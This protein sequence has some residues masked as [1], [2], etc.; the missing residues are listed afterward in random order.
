MTVHSLIQVI[1]QNHDTVTYH[2]HVNGIKLPALWWMFTHIKGESVF[3]AHVGTFGW[4]I[5]ST[6]RLRFINL[7]LQWYSF[8]ITKWIYTKIWHEFYGTPV[9][10]DTI[11]FIPLPNSKQLVQFP[12]KQKA[13]RTQKQETSHPVRR[14]GS[15]SISCLPQTRELLY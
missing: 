4:N 7:R 11:H 6:T 2:E 3:S 12:E 15:K 13:N 1:Y 5:V 9:C 14:Y 10:P 8:E